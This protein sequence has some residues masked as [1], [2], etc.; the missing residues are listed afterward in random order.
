[1][2]QNEMSK[3]KEFYQLQT[4]LLPP[5]LKKEIDE[6][7]IAQLISRTVEELNMEIYRF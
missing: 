7:D 4:M 2:Q 6:D 3:F 1:M 5:G